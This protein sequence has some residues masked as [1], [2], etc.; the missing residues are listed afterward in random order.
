MQELE[1][2]VSHCYTYHRCANNISQICC[3]VGIET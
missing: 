2:S 1:H 3:F